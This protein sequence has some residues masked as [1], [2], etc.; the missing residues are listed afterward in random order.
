MT[1]HSRGN[2]NTSVG[3]VLDAR[4]KY[5]FMFFSAATQ[6]DPWPRV[7]LVS[8]VAR[9]VNPIERETHQRYW[10]DQQRRGLPNL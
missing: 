5:R 10:E 6:P 4:Y 8:A 2:T 7:N 9:L 3:L 1:G